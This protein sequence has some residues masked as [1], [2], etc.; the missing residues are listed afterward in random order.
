M[1]FNRHTP[2]QHDV[3]I[4]IDVGTCQLKAAVVSLRGDRLEL[5][6]Y[7]VQ[8]MNASVGQ[9]EAMQDLADQ[10]QQLS[11]EFEKNHRQTSVTISCDSAIVCHTELQRVP[12]EQ[13]KNTLRH[14]GKDYVPGDPSTYY[15]DA[16]ELVEP[17]SDRDAARSDR[18]HVLVGGAA[19]Q[20]VNWYRDAFRAAQVRPETI[21]LTA[22]SVVNAFQISQPALCQR[23]VVLLLDIGGRFTSINFLRHGQPV[24]TRLVKFG[25]QQLSEYIA[26]LLTMDS[27]QAEEEKI[28]MSEPVQVL[29]QTAIQPLAKEVR[30]SI[31]AFQHAHN[32][33]VDVAF[34]CGG[35]ACSTKM[36]EL[37]G[38]QVGLP[39]ASWNPVE[40]FETDHFN[41]DGE[42]LKNLAPCLAAAVGAAIARLRN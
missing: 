4:G 27:R 17:A 5:T 36:L 33:R 25:G 22:V 11:G 7:A 6:A 24:F 19:K 31:D 30:E 32:C 41:G 34:A 16:T 28:N 29:L 3:A 26:Q 10:L 23:E 38:E 9:P 20:E 18:M 40:N 12:I 13:L 1:I 15:L 21:E 2:F 8:P 14:D 42:R 37:L 35:S 39:I